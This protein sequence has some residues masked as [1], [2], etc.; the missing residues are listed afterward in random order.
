MSTTRMG[1]TLSIVVHRRGWIR[2]EENQAHL[3]QKEASALL[4]LYFLRALTMG[5]FYFF[6][7]F[8]F[9]CFRASTFY[10]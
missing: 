5:E 9:L 8:Q 2:E 4:I 10:F 1:V 3:G 7:I 6:S